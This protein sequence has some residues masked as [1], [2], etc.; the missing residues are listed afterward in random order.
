MLGHAVTV[1]EAR[2]K[3]VRPERVRHRRLQDAARVRAARGRF[4]AGHRRHRS[5]CRIKR[6]GAMSRWSALRRD[7]DAVFLGIGLAGTK[8][9]GDRGRGSG[10][11]R[12]C[13][14]LHRAPA[15]GAGSVEAAGRAPRRGDRRRQHRDRHRGADQ[16]ARRRG[17][18]H[19]LSARPEAMSAT[20]HEQEFAQIN[21][22]RIKHW[23]RPVRLVGERWPASSR[24]SSSTPSS[25]RRAP[26]RH[27]RDVLARGRP[28]VQGDRPG[29]GAGSDR[30]TERKQVLEMRGRQD[31]GRRATR[32]TSLPGVW[33]GGDCVAGAD[34]TVQAVQDGK[35]AAH[36]I[37]RCLRAG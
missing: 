25:M 18:D 17:R 9:L 32:Q 22:V 26:G 2:P 30:G 28:G 8:A 35:V 10:R 11:R 29:A 15:P 20:A 7:Y 21:G 12:G 31:R 33:A 13:G 1:F 3:L 23:A 16:A 36:A 27:R 6:S 4:H 24:W 14:R 37:D 34:L 19:G 5:A